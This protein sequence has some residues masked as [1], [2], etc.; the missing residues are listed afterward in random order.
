MP[1][2]GSSGPASRCLH[3]RQGCARPRRRRPGRAVPRGVRLRRARPQLA[4][5]RRA[6]S[7]SS[8]RAAGE[9]VVVEVKTR[10]G[11]GF[12]H[13]FEAIDASQAARAVAPGHGVDRGAIPTRRRGD[14]CAWTRSRSDRP[15]PGDRRRS[16]ISRTC[17]DDRAH[18][19][20]SRSPA[21][22]A[23]LVEVE[24]DLS[25][26]TP[27]FRIIGLPDKAL[28][29]AVQRV[30][31]ASANCG[32]ALPRR[33]LTVNLSPASLPKHGSGFDVAIAI[34]VARDRGCDGCRLHRADR[35]HRRAGT[36]R[37]P[38]PRA[39]RAARGAWP[40]PVRASAGSSCRTR[41]RRRP[42]S[43]RASR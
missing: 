18:V 17:G 28:G 12:G 33:R 5:A 6:R 23:T 20:R 21:S 14:G 11:D 24:A 26:Q 29:E 2:A 10:R 32:L 38:A 30:H 8:S 42:R 4:H 37:T 15:R 9:L 1:C 16:S 25:N 27:E 31:N 22:T 41:T 36:R 43:S 3:G 13:P 34:A 19:G 39:G 35:A 40:P 7:T